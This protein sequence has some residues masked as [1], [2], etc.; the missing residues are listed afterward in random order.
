MRLSL[1]FLGIIFSCTLC[2]DDIEQQE[3]TQRIQPVGKVRVQEEQTNATQEQPKPVEEVT[4]VKRTPGQ[5]KYEQYCV[6][7]HKDGLAGAP[8]LHNAADWAPRLKGRTIDDLVAS[9]VKG[10]NA[11]P[12][13]GTC[14]D[15]TEDD[16]KAI[17]Q[18]MLPKS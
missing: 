16:L 12:A 3:I 13:K 6:V 7:C 11:M 2:A 18:Y 17:I 14:N 4:A 9:A 5:D 15:C 1:A 8:K 10:L